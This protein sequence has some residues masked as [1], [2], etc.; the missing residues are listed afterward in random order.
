MTHPKFNLIEMDT[1]SFVGCDTLQAHCTNRKKT[2]DNEIV[3][4]HQTH[5]ITYKKGHPSK[6]FMEYYADIDI[7]YDNNL[8]NSF[9][10]SKILSNEDFRRKIS[11]VRHCQYYILSAERFLQ[12]RRKIYS[13]C[14]HTF[15]MI[16][17]HSTWI[18]CT[19]RCRSIM[20]PIE[21]NCDEDS[22]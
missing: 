5:S 4:W 17:I 1:L 11:S 12:R 15:H 6:L 22:D 2:T 8:E 3:S 9:D 10:R 7:K 21:W 19:S 16:S 18:F 20:M 14:W 13:T